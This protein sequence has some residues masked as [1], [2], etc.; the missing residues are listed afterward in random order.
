[1]LHVQIWKAQ[2]HPLLLRVPDGNDSVKMLSLPPDKL[3]ALF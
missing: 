2:A 3:K 1:M